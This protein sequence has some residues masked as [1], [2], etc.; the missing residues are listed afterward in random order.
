LVS[1]ETIRFDMSKA[2]SLF[3]RA[4]VA[5]D[6]EVVTVTENGVNRLAVNAELRRAVERLCEPG[7]ITAVVQPIV[8]T[9]DLVTVGYEALARM[10]IEPQNPPNWWLDVASEFGLRHRLEV[11]CLVAAVQLGPPPEG[12]VLFV[13]ASPSTIDD[14][15]LLELRDELPQRLVIELTEQEEVEDYDHLRNRLAGWLERGV[16]LA[17]D[18]AG[19]GY[20]S[21][22]HVVELS[23][24][25]LKLDCELVRGIDKDPNRREL[26]RAV[27]AF[28][29]E[30]GTTV[31]AEGVETR[32]E[33]DVLRD[34]EVHLVQG[35]LL[36]RPGPPW[37]QITRTGAPGSLLTG[38]MTDSN[39]RSRDR[40]D[41]LR[42]A[43]EQIDNVLEAGDV[44]VET[45]FRQGRLMPSLY[46][47]RNGEL[48]CVAQRGL[49]QVL[50]GMPGTAGITGRTWATG[51]TIVIDDVSSHPDYREA[52]PGVV[53]E[54]CVPILVNGDPVGS[55]N[56]ESFSSLDRDTVAFTESVARLLA[57]RLGVIGTNIGN[58]RWQRAA[59]ASVAISG[60]LASKRLPQQV[61]HRFREA[62]EMD[63][64]C[65]IV[66]EP[67]GLRV[68][69]ALGPLAA[70]LLALT[71]RE[72]NDLCSLVGDIRSCYTAGD[73]CSPGFVGT[74]SLRSAGARGVVVLPLWA[75]RKRFGTILLANSRPLVLTGDRVEPLELL[76]DHAAAVLRPVLVADTAQA[77]HW[78]ASVGADGQS[79][80][81]S[82]ESA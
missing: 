2:C 42:D 50:D 44:V 69:A 52:V 54:I 29:R 49:W 13:N 60:L 57:D 40:E 53:S 39:S 31:I 51:K 27:V 35:Y 1:I 30:V 56:V 46:L 71:T 37:P 19:A 65:L 66:D 36:A 62:A 64:A 77:E 63:S 6:K 34:A 4:V 17:V 21:L 72:L 38:A 74:G 28:A 9:A 33:L 16:R 43:L 78:V 55:L 26:M 48:R 41:R 12:R 7:A 22:R 11:A 68:V 10:P 47:E 58:S 75:Q 81:G 23:P 70:S 76:A 67:E 8:R 14:P 5:A 79:A 15:T 3:K 80:L 24:D 32:A 82:F 25:Y 61:L 45:L 73:A 20:S 59:Q 18:D